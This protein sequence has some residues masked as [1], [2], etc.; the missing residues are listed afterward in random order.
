MSMRGGRPVAIAAELPDSGWPAKNRMLERLAARLIVGF[1]SAR[2]CGL[3]GD[4]G[5]CRPRQ[6]TPRELPL[7]A[8]PGRA[9]TVAQMYQGESTGALM[10]Q[11]ECWPWAVGGW[12]E[13][14]GGV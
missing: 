2:G 11:V 8:S 7:S 4:N 12:C 10:M 13:T 5:R 3:D 1:A 6:G 9:R 14:T